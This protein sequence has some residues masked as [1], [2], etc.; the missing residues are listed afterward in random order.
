[1]AVAPHSRAYDAAI[2][3]EAGENIVQ[4]N[5]DELMKLARADDSVHGAKN[6]ESEARRAAEAGGLPIP[7][8]TAD[9]LAVVARKA[10]NGLMKLA[11]ADDSVHG[12]KD[13][14]SEAR[15]AAEAGGLPIPSL[16]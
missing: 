7:R 13:W 8:L 15:R 1:M 2:V 4:E 12:A 9:E 5:V 11:R 6:W 14:E 10:V 3:N 16:D